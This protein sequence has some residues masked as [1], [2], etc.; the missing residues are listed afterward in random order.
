MAG[1]ASQS[2]DD[3]SAEDLAEF[4]IRMQ[5]EVEALRGWKFKHP[6]DIGLYSEEQVQA[7]IDKPLDREVGWSAYSRAEVAMKMIGLIP[8]DSGLLSTTREMLTN[9]EPPGIYD[10]KTKKLR[11]VM[12]PGMDLDSLSF[13]IIFIH[14]LTHALDD[15]YFDLE[16]ME[17]IA[18]SSSDAEIVIGSIVEGSAMTVQQRY[19]DKVVRLG[20]ANRGQAMLSLASAMGDMQAV[21]T[22]P[23]YFTTYFARFS[24]GASFLQFG[25]RALD[26]S[27]NAPPKQVDARSEDQTEVSPN[28]GGPTVRSIGEAMRTAAVDLPRSSEQILHPE[29]FW[30]AETRDEPIMVQDGD[31]E[32][33]L[34]REG[35]HVVHRNTFGELKCAVLTFAE[36]KRISPADIPM[37][38]SD[39]TNRSATGWG[40]DRFFLLTAGAKEESYSG[41]PKGLLGLWFTMWDTADDLEEFIE[42]YE[43]YRPSPSRGVL[44]LGERCAVFFFGFEDSRLMSLQERLESSPP[45]FTKDGK[46]WLLEAADRSVGTN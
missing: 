44:R 39:W 14:E 19:L 16:K 13:Q 24:C 30:R 26:S 28:E 38:P 21:F 42:G 9:M 32:K 8:Q 33:L 18:L 15:Q 46:P 27:F 40:G 35:L 20:E 3:L 23:L 22:A 12:K 41:Q 34:T 1:Q 4:G 10:A 45:G 11:T 29:K 25:A 43:T 36:E 17:E 37:L 2:A 6:V 31:V 5:K 7:F